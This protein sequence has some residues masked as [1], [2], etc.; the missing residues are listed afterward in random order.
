[1]KVL[2]AFGNASALADFVGLTKQGVSAWKKVPRTY[3]RAISERTGISPYRIR[4]D[5]YVE[6]FWDMGKNT[7]EIA[8]EMAIA[9]PEICHILAEVLEQRRN[10]VHDLTY[11]TL[12]SVRKP[13]LE[14]D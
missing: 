11:P 1:M 3:I 13:P 14:S 9:E 2:L 8:R 12:S 6:A 5:I 4:P 10:R 7:A